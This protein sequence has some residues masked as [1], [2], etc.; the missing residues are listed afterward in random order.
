MRIL[1]AIVG[2]I[3]RIVHPDKPREWF[4][5]IHFPTDHTAEEVAESL[6][7]AAAANPAFKNWRTS[8]VDLM[9]LTHEDGRDEAA[10]MANRKQLAAELGKPDY[11]GTAEEN[12][13]L[14]AHVFRAIQQRGI[15]LPKSE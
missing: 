11:S 10:S 9:K 6:D 4:A 7:K 14:H 1:N 12:V 5:N 15:P 13:W 3:A 2:A 8:I